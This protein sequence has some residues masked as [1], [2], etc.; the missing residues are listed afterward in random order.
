MSS[1]LRIC[2]KSIWGPGQISNIPY[3]RGCLFS[4]EERRENGG[5]LQLHQNGSCS[6][7]SFQ[8][9]YQII[10]PSPSHLWDSNHPEHFSS[11]FVQL[12]EPIP[13][14]LA[15][16]KRVISCNNKVETSCTT[17]C[18]IWKHIVSFE[19]PSGSNMRDVYE[20]QRK[21]KKNSVSIIHLPY[22]SG[23]L[24]FFTCTFNI[25]YWC[26]MFRQTE[27]KVD[28]G[29]VLYS[30]SLVWCLKSHFSSIQKHFVCVAMA[31]NYMNVIQIMSN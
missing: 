2:N 29:A 28:E 15:D 13:R 12:H 9:V 14:G 30:Y 23:L 17:Y 5:W 10:P 1:H 18:W 8:T 25:I 19:V 31:I 20:G 27:G 16:T 4:H 3:Q 26:N 22:M 6:Y 24:L 7:S 11:S 21:V